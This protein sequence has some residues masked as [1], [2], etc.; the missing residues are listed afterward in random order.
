M[1]KAGS[2]GRRDGSAEGNRRLKDHGAAEQ[3]QKERVRQILAR[4]GIVGCKIS[5]FDASGEPGSTLVRIWPPDQ[6]T[7]KWKVLVERHLT[8]HAYAESCY[9]EDSKT[10]YDSLEEAFASLQQRFGVRWWD[11]H[12]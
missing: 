7:K 9:L 11:L 1:T 10:L 12:A 6:K 3:N 4:G 2:K 8:K 5:W